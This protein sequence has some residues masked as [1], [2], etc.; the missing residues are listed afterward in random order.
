MENGV[1][2]E[3]INTAYIYDDVEIGMDTI[4]KPNVVIE[5]NVKIGKECIIGP[6]VYIE[7]GNVL[8]DG[9]KVEPFTI[10]NKKGEFLTR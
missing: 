8:K 5:N 3:D 6:N 4:I 10:I 9:T 1:T 2:I 7:E